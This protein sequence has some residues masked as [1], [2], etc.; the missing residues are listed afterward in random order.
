MMVKIRIGVGGRARGSQSITSLPTKKIELEK[1]INRLL[2][3]KS[4]TAHI[5]RVKT[6][7]QVFV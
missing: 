2:T 3:H 4:L 7:F 6:F 1:S 5:Q